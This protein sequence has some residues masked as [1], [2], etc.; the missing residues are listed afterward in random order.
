MKCKHCGS[1]VKNYGKKV[2]AKEHAKYKTFTLLSILMPYLSFIIDIV[3]LV[4]EDELDK[5]VGEHCIATS[6]VAALIWSAIY[7]VFFSS[8]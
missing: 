1:S 4:K 3:Y 5:K 2:H 8:L 7:V 6:I